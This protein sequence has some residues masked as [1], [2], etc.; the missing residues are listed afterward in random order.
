MES[1]STPLIEKTREYVAGYIGDNFTEKICYHNIDHTI[2]VVE[3][4]ELIGQQSGIS[5][6][7]LEIIIIAAWFHDTGYYLGCENHEEASAVIAKEYLEME[8][9]SPEVIEKVF[10]CILSTKIPQQPKTDLEE[11]ICDADLIHLS[12]ERFFEKSQLLLHEILFQNHD[13]SYVQWLKESLDFVLEHKY[14]TAYGKDVLSPMLKN[15]IDLI[16]AKINELES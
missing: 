6:K 3:A 12:S 14:H 8:K 13:I 7:D 5:D 10:N 2:E 9:V 15:N 1:F 11:V 16:R 4:S